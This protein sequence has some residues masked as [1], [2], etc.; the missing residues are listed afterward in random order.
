MYRG[1][2]VVLAVVTS[3]LTVLVSLLMWS[4]SVSCHSQWARSGFQTEWGPVKGCLIS[5]DGKTW[6]PA[7]NYREIP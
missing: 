6:I 7:K 5:K 2:V 3:L 4:S 1:D